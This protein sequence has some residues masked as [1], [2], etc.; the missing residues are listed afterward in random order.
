MRKNPYAGQ[1]GLTWQGQKAISAQN[2]DWEPDP[3]KKPYVMRSG[4]GFLSF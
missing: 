1:L 3:F 2:P 4:G